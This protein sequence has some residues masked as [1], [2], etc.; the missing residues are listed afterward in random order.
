MAVQRKRDDWCD[1]GDK[2]SAF[3]TADGGQTWNPTS[4]EL[5]VCGFAAAFSAD[6]MVGVIAGHSNTAFMST[7][8]GQT[9]NSTNLALKENEAARVAFSASPI[10]GVVVGNRDLHETELSSEL[11]NGQQSANF[12]AQTTNGD[13]Y[14]FKKYQELAPPRSPLDWI[15]RR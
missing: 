15:R 12:L 3:V 1:R 4:F 9:W 11:T 10:T 8:R 2:G 7:D 5:S 13:Y 14:L 6:G